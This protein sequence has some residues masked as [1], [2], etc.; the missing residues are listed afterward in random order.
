M[1]ISLHGRTCTSDLTSIHIAKQYAFIWFRLPYTIW[2]A[3]LLLFSDIHNISAHFFMWYCDSV[4]F[5]CISHLLRPLP[6]VRIEVRAINRFLLASIVL[7]HRSR[8]SLRSLFRE[9]ATPLY[10]SR[11]IPIYSREKAEKPPDFLYISKF[12]S[13]FAA[14]F[15][16]YE[17]NYI[18]HLPYG[19]QLVHAGAIAESNVFGLYCHLSR[20]GDWA[21]T[22]VQRASS[23]HHGARY[24][25]VGS[26]TIGARQESQEPL[27]SITPQLIPSSIISLS[28][29][30]PLP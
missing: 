11:I 17:E 20:H 24:I 27:L 26:R 2:T 30:M 18:I 8:S 19:M 1:R 9:C 4:V 7:S 14:K 13:T 6:I 25:G 3:K 12:F 29:E 15:D 5:S 21:T 22:Q 23:N 16:E 28:L 10:P